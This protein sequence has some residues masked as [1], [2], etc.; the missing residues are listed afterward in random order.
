MY[1]NTILGGA[2]K[3]GTSS[4]YFW[5]DAHPEVESSRIKEPFFFHDEINRFNAKLNF[6]KHG[7]E[8][9]PELFESCKPN[10]VV[11]EATATYIYQ[12]TALEQ[13]PNLPTTPKMVFVLREPASRLLSK[14]RFNRYKLHNINYSFKDFCSQDGSFPSGLHYNEGFYSRYLELWLKALGHERLKIYLFE[15]LMRNPHKIMRDLCKFLEINPSFYD[16]FE[17]QKHNETFATRF[18]G[19]HKWAVSAMGWIPKPLVKTLLPLYKLINASHTPEM[20]LEEHQFEQK[21]KTLYKPDQKVLKSLFP[22]LP[23]ELWK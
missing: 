10:K 17:F 3:S 19:L 1:P 20:T 16:H 21:L 23:L 14:Y 8:S 2:P 11:F 6:H 12:K 5:L 4:M 13:I 15:D 18:G 7:L 22:N 9:Y